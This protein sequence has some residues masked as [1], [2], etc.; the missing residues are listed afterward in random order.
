L[1]WHFVKASKCEVRVWQTEIA[2][3]RQYPMDDVTPSPDP[4]TKSSWPG[5][6]SS[7]AAYLRPEYSGKSSVRKTFSTVLTLA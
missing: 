6:R 1:I 2:L 5:F 3:L 7:K 4:E